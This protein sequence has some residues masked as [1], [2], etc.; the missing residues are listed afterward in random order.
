MT[1]I[2]K[3]LRDPRV[4]TALVLAAVVVVGLALIGQG[5]RGA[6]DTL[7]V[8]FQVPFLVSGAMAGIAVLGGGLALLSA[9][10]E[11]T[12]AAEERRAVADLQRDV[13]CV[14][15]P[16]RRRRGSGGSRRRRRLGSAADGDRGARG[17]R[18][19][20]VTVRGRRGD[21]GG[22]A[23]GRRPVPRAP[24]HPW[25]LA[26]RRCARSPALVG[27]RAGR[28]AADR[29]CRHGVAVGDDRALAVL[30]DRW[31]SQRTRCLRHE[32]R[33][34]AGH[35]RPQGARRPDGS[36]L[37]GDH[38]R[39]GRVPDLAASWSSRRPRVHGPPSCSSPRRVAR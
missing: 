38:R 14:C 16:R 20:R 5:Y 1:E 6:A 30:G 21:R 33:S 34:G 2:W 22:R 11:R 31:A 9:H 36:R 3:A 19:R 7:V 35:P 37:P 23:A 29:A 17:A 4:S 12:E 39:G 32:G 18:P 10:L 25:C 8:P 28:G 27:W 26:R 24:G 13:L 15:W